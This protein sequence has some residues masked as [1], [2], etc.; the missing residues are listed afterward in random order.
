MQAS[1]T[2]NLFGCVNELAIIIRDEASQRFLQQNAPGL[3]ML[4]LLGSI[5]AFFRAELCL[6]VA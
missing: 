1:T 4:L 6:D 5:A 3:Q 2:L